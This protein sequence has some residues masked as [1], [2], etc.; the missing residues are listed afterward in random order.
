MTHAIQRLAQYLLNALLSL[1]VIIYILLEGFFWLW[2]TKPLF[3]AISSLGYF[4]NVAIDLKNLNPYVALIIFIFLVFIDDIFIVNAGIQVVRGNFL[5]ATFLY[6]IKILIDIVTIWFF[7]ET[8]E[9][10]MKFK[11]LKWII[12]KISNGLVWVRSRKTYLRTKAHVRLMKRLI[13]QNISSIRKKYFS[14]KGVIITQIKSIYRRLKKNLTY[15]H[16]EKKYLFYPSLLFVFF[17]LYS[18]FKS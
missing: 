12:D 17:T 11:V 18:F 6:I 8:R 9:S 16:Q 10:L 13:K 3:K 4:R 14:K 15:L 5:I 7:T 1:F 2:F